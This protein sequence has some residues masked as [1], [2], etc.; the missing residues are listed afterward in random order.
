VWRQGRR[1]LGQYF[2][3]RSLE[4]NAVDTAILKCFPGADQKIAV[5]K[6]SY[7]TIDHARFRS[8]VNFLPEFKPVLCARICSAA[9]V[10]LI[11][12]GPAASLAQS[13]SPKPRSPGEIAAASRLLA[14]KNEG[15]RRQAREQKLTFLKR[16]RFMRGC[17]KDSQ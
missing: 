16:R 5:I 17:V 4:R 1:C 12:A 11:L 8:K 10:A 6:L 2:F 15:C 7:T 13:P 3:W 14:Q 9:F